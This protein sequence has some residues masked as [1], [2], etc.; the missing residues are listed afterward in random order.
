M[1]VA[2]CDDAA[3]LEPGGN[4]MIDG[5]KIGRIGRLSKQIQKR[6][7]L[8]TPIHVAQLQLGEMLAQYPPDVQ[9]RPLPKQPA[10]ER[11]LSIM[12]DESCSWSDIESAIESL[13]LD[14]L[15]SI[16]FVTTFRGKNVEAGKKSLSLRLCFRDASRT[17]THEE[18]NGPVTTAT[19]M[20][21]EKFG[22]EIRSS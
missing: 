13:T 12:I 6:W 3:W 19:N 22:A 2:P 8:P 20:L 10:I 5:V 7:N 21:T 16:H 1:T 11:D 9:S 15:E 4:I 18:V 17:L 14:H